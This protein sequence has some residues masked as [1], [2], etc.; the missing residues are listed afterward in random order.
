MPIKI[1][2]DLPAFSQLEKENIFVMT[3]DRAASQDIRPLKIAIVNL[4]PTK[5]VTET[6][7]LR[8][9]SNTPLQI[10]ISL[11]QIKGHVS[12]N[13]KKTHLDKFYIYS[14][15][16]YTKKF[17]GMII[18]GAPV[19]QIPFEDVDYWSELCRI[20]DYAKK[21]VFCTLYICWGAMAGLYHLYGINK[22]VVEKKYSGIF[23]SKLLDSKEPLMRGFDDFFPVPTSR[24]TFIKSSDVKKCKDLILLA[25][26]S[27]T[28]LTMAKSKDNR[29]IFMTGHLE[30]DPD[31]LKN[32]F[33]RDVKKGLNPSIPENYFSDD[34]PKNPVVSKWRSTAH[35]FYSNWL[36][37]YVYQNTP[38]RLKNI[39]KDVS[40]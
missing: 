33:I 14:D 28:G 16:I 25:E 2:E 20:M 23:Y 7:L 8:L 40:N 39:G 1:D 38:Y 26:S 19:E 13:T 29:S 27:V 6:Q 11:V 36:N 17:D 21:N 30:Y 34:D 9:L 37:Y 3:Q 22:H 4:M 15:E 5:E 10:D 18:T 32:E 31:T 12:K 24:Y 35:L